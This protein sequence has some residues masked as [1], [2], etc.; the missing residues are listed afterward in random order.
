MRHWLRIS[1]L[2]A[3]IA[4]VFAIAP[5]RAQTTDPEAMRKAIEQLRREFEQ[6]RKQYGDRLAALEAKVAASAVVTQDQPAVAATS[7]APAPPAPAPQ[8]PAEAGIQTQPAPAP[9]GASSAGASKV[10]NPDISAI[11]NFLGT[12]GNS[13]GNPDPGKALEL[14]ESEIALQA[15][16]DPYARADF[17]LSFGEE[18]VSVEEGFVTFPTIPGGLLLKVGKMRAA[19]GK[20]NGLHTHVLPWADRPLVTRNLVGGEDGINDAGISAARLIPNPWFFLEA[21]GQLFRGDSAD[22]FRSS[23][24][25][26]LAYLARLRAYQDLSESTNVDL[27]TSFATGHNNSGVTNGI[28]LGRF[29]TRLFGLDATLRWK[30]LQRSIYRS[31]IARSEFVWSRREQNDGPQSAFGYYVS[32][33]YQLGRRWFTGVRVDRSAHADHAVLIDTGQALV[34]TYVPSEF[35]IIRGMYRRTRYAQQTQTANEFLMQFQ[36]AIGAHGAHPF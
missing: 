33:D 11:G 6:I 27:G 28:D 26:D 29:T 32:G 13:T 22:V 30:P 24:R 10:F 15:I 21:T 36:F 19:F 5:A 18:G 8:A 16:V 12:G 14:H 3:A 2:V 35:S 1:A 20:V 17:F 23:Q 34:L 9:G 4:L 7:P 31:F 25:S